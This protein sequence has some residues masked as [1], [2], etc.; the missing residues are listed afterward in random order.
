M[1]VKVNF[2]LT[3]HLFCCGTAGGIIVFECLMRQHF[4]LDYVAV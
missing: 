2:N 4:R 1:V 3:V